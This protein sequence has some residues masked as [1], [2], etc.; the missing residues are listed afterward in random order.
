MINISSESYGD[1]REINSSYDFKLFMK[2]TSFTG[3]ENVF[4]SDYLLGRRGR[5][6]KKK[7]L[8]SS[9]IVQFLLR[10]NKLGNV[11]NNCLKCVM[12]QS[13]M[14]EMRTPYKIFIMTKKAIQ[15]MLLVQAIL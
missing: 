10:K 6:R 7:L 5:L 12:L 13:K 9:L 14:I 2:S 3:Y 15:S 4:K 11:H 1:F 8:H